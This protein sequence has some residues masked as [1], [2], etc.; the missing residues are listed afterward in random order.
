MRPLIVAQAMVLASMASGCASIAD[1]TL[2]NGS[3]VTFSSQPTGAKVM[4]GNRLICQTPCRE[5]IDSSDM[6]RLV[7]ILPGRA[8]VKIQPQASLNGAIVGNVIAGGGVGLAIDAISGRAVR[9]RDQI[10]ITF[11][12]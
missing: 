8:D 11:A 9:Y 7:A 4:A 1:G 6:N 5:R 10:H 3:Y 12:D 2:E